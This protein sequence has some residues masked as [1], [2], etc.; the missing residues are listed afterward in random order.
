M[1]HPPNPLHSCSFL[2]TAAIWIEATQSSTRC[3]TTQVLTFY[4]QRIGLPPGLPL[5]G[6]DDDNI[7]DPETA[8]LEMQED[9]EEEDTGD[10]D[11]N[12][13][14]EQDHD[15]DREDQ[16]ENSDDSKDKESDDN[17]DS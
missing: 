15:G 16:D 3:S 11:Y 2:C 10:D 5:M 6:K 13:G 7:Y 1:D 12:D 4:A 8:F 14:M 9:D 17:D